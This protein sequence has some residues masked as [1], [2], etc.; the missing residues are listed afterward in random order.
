VPH[1][2]IR[3]ATIVGVALLIPASAPAQT[4]RFGSIG[5]VDRV[6]EQEED[7][8][9][10]DDDPRANGFYPEFRADDLNLDKRAYGVGVRLHSNTAT[11]VRFDVAH[12]DE[13]WH[14]MTRLTD[15]FRLRRLS[16]RTAA[17]PFVP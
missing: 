15:P 14:L 16:R 13:G 7:L 17:I 2:R 6:V 11:F 9:G 10:G 8:K 3:A 12:G 1:G 4:P 5:L